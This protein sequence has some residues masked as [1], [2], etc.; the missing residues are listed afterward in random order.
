MHQQGIYFLAELPL[1]LDLINKIYVEMFVK[2]IVIQVAKDW[3]KLLKQLTT[4]Q[5]MLSK[6]DSFYSFYISGVNILVF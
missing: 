4:L 2:S 5:L 3:L 6:F 1:S